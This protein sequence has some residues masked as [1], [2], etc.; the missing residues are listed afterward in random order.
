M[1]KWILITALSLHQI[2]CYVRRKAKL[3]L[4]R[5]SRWSEVN[6][7]LPVLLSFTHKCN[8]KMFL[9]VTHRLV[10]LPN[11][12]QLI[13]QKARVGSIT[14]SRGRPSVQYLIATASP[15]FCWNRLVEATTS[16]ESNSGININKFLCQKFTRYNWILEKHG[17]RMWIGFSWLR[18]WSIGGLLCTRQLTFVFRKWR[19]ISCLAK[20]LSTF[21]VRHSSRE[22]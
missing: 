11:R 3:F 22:L 8:Y 15:F 7:F 16:L 4:H 1:C 9:S 2:Y 21:Q 20:R 13:S 18:I 12:S 10:T 17:V 5:Q 6:W 19:G 14:P